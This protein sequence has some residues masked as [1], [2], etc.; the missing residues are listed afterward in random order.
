MLDTF[1]VTKYVRSI[2][3]V[4]TILDTIDRSVSRFGVTGTRFEEKD[5]CSSVICY[6]IDVLEHTRT[7][8]LRS[9]VQYEIGIDV[10]NS[11]TLHMC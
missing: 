5:V 11:G 2:S 4:K 7:D 9:T 10:D 3:L 6:E 1:D 8:T